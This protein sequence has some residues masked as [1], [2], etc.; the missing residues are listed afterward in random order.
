MSQLKGY[1]HLA[2]GIAAG[3]ILSGT[4]A[5]MIAAGAGALLPDLDTPHS[6]LG[7]KIPLLSVIGGGHRGW[8]HSLIGLAVFSL[9]VY[10]YNPQAGYAVATGCITH[11]VLDMLNPSG[12]KLF[13]PFGRHRHILGIPSSSI[14]ANLAVTVLVLFAAFERR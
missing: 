9:P 11:F 5:G 14:I 4:P 8:M 1:A 10:L 13:W 7:S 6:M 3:Y 12:V 2:A